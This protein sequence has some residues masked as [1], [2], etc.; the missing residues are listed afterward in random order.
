MIKNKLHITDSSIFRPPLLKQHLSDLSTSVVDTQIILSSKVINLG[1][2]FDQYL[3]FLD[4]FSGIC[5]STHFHLKS[6]ERIR[7]L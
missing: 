4:N 1:V 3:T 6:I 2:V 5:K 7:N